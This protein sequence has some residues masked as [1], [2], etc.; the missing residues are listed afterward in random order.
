M[1]GSPRKKYR[2][3]EVRTDIINVAVQGRA[4]LLE[5]EVEEQCG[6][7][8]KAIAQVIKG[9]ASYTDWAYIFDAVN[10]I[11]QV[12]GLSKRVLVTWRDWHSQ[13]QDIILAVATR[14]KAGGR[15]LYADEIKE[16]HRLAEVWRDVMTNIS[17]T[18]YFT[19]R[20]AAERKVRAALQGS[21]PKVRLMSSDGFSAGMAEQIERGFVETL[22]RPEEPA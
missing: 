3:R 18:E 1:M 7:I 19:A 20:G 15:A 12:G 21:S 16:L 6:Y 14:Q 9:E 2:P 22:N 11:E 4:L 8:D 17:R 13:A 5:S 10:I